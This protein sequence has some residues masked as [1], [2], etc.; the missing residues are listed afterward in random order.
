MTQPKNALE[1]LHF[2]HNCSIII[3]ECSEGCAICSSD[4]QCRACNPGYSLTGSVCTLCPTGFYP[5][6]TTSPT[7]NQSNLY[8]SYFFNFL[9]CPF[10]CLNC[11]SP[12]TCQGCQPPYKFTGSWCDA[13]PNGLYAENSTS[14]ECTESNLIS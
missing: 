7:C 5:L 11:T 3:I 14:T 4:L 2:L 10:N 8:Y 9:A 1:V 6:T 13:C 12:S